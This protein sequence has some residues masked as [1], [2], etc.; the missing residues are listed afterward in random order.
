M[1]SLNI[2]KGN[3]VAWVGFADKK[4]IYHDKLGAGKSKVIRRLL[5]TRQGEKFISNIDKDIRN[6]ARLSVFKTLEKNKTY[7]KINFVL[8][9]KR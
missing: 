9:G 2:R 6:L 8:S 1:N 3:G 5:P 7:M 4:A